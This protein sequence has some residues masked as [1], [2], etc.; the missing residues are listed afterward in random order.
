M[1]D[2]R[3]PCLQA[4]DVPEGDG[5]GRTPVGKRPPGQP[6]DEG[7]GS[8]GHQPHQAERL[9]LEARTWFLGRLV[10]ARG[11]FGS[12]CHFRSI[13]A[14]TPACTALASHISRGSNTVVAT[15]VMITTAANATRPPPACTAVKEPNC[16]MATSTDT[17]KMSMLDQR[18]MA[19]M[20]R[21]SRV[22]VTSRRC[23]PRRVA[24]SIQVSPKSLMSGR[25]MLA[26]NTMTASGHRSLRISSRTPLRMVLCSS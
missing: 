3:L 18:P 4:L 26:V 22:R 20:D 6:R 25:T 2:L 1:L 16:R 5:D 19:S 13:G 12:L 10:L 11:V 21:Y 14:R 9:R 8:N 15:M 23:D 17:E 24:T 7:C